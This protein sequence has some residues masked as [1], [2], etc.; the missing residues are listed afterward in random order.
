MLRAARVD[1]AQFLAAVRT[2]ADD[3]AVLAALERQAPGAIERLLCFSR[4]PPPG[5]RLWVHA[6]DFDDG[7]VTLPGSSR[8]RAVSPL[9]F[10]PLATLLRRV[11]PLKPETEAGA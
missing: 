8:W 6:L 2:A 10:R 11:F 4:R 3:G 5:V 9:I 1:Y 7:Y